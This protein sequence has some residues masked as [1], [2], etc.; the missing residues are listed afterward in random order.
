[1]EIV[2]LRHAGCETPE[3]LLPRRD[4]I[5]FVEPHTELDLRPQLLDVRLTEDLRGPGLARGA[6]AD[7]VDRVLAQ[8]LQLDLRQLLLHRSADAL[9]VEIGE[10]VRF[11]VARRPDHRVAG[12][13]A[14]DGLP[15]L[16]RVS[17]RLVGPELDHRP[18]GVPVAVEDVDV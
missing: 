5:R 6:D 1:M 2:E 11:R 16:G 10:K 13:R 8:Q 18:A 17:E 3:M 14:D 7:P 4:R 12:P 9:A 15:P